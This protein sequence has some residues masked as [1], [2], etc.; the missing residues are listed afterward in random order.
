MRN[1]VPVQPG[2]GNGH[3]EPAARLMCCCNCRRSG[4]GEGKL[5]EED[6][7]QLEP[8]VSVTILWLPIS[9]E[10][11]TGAKAEPGLVQGVRELLVSGHRGK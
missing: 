4:V 1:S 11:A 6:A 5:G 10:K 2:V 7:E 9:G 8:R 3:R